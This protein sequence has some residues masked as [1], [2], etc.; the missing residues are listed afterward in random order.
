MVLCHAKACKPVSYVSVG[1]LQEVCGPAAKQISI[2]ALLPAATGINRRSG[3]APGQ[4]ASRLRHRSGDW[5]ALPDSEA[6]WQRIAQI[7]RRHDAEREIALVLGGYLVA[8]ALLRADR[9]RAA[10][11]QRSPRRLSVARNSRGC[12]RSGCA[13]ARTLLTMTARF[14]TTGRRAGL[15]GAAPRGSACGTWIDR[16]YRGG[17]C[18]RPPDSNPHWIKVPG[19][20]TL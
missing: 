19:N 6:T 7:I 16:R 9:S 5:A 12:R 11:I 2:L 4:V 17:S 1:A 13:A 15:G 10:H 18:H 8:P 20:V 14:I 3:P